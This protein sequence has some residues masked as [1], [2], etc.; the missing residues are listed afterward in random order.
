MGIS[1]TRD[2]FSKQDVAAFSTQVQDQLNVLKHLLAQPDFGEGPSTLGAELEYYLV[3]RDLNPIPRNQEVLAQ[4]DDP[5]FTVELNRFNLEFNLTP[6]PFRGAPFSAMEIDLANALV[7]ID[8]AAKPHGGRAV[9]IGILP[10]LRASHFN[11]R[12]MTDIPRYRALSRS[13]RE[14]RGRPFEIHID[15]ADPLDFIKDD[16]TLEGA[17]TSFQVHWR[18]NPCQFSAHFN[19]VQLMTPLA[20]ALGANSPSFLGHLLWDETRIAL[21]K[22]AIDSR[23]MRDV[24]WHEPPRVSFG[25]GW[26]RLGAWELFA[27]SLALYPPLLPVTDN[28]APRQALQEGRCPALNALRLHQGTTWP[29]NRAIYDPGAG[30]HL[31][32][33][34]RALP[35][36]PTPADMSATALF[37][38]GGALALLPAIDHLTATLPFRYAEQNFYRAAK[39]GIDATLIWPSTTGVELQER[40]VLDIARDLLPRVRNSLEETALDQGEVDRL[41]AVIQTRIDSRMTPARWQRQWVKH[42]QRTLSTEEAFRAMLV[43]YVENQDRHKPLSEWSLAP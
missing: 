32:I 19:A 9:P 10:T 30:G 4:L 38:I 14:L 35:S 34:M 24:G 8:A 1:V 20:V 25:E 27:E 37:L 28:E 36:G 16:V 33:E 5:Q 22:Q 23:A 42:F 29:W 31:R 17:N 2:H 15:G 6:Q 43:L 41:L 21:F 26:V 7:R 3:D 39:L 18:I 13:L 12:T 40:P 11:D